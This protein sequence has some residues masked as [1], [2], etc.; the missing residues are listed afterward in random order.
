LKVLLLVIILDGLKDN[1]KSNS[2]NVVEL[3]GLVFIDM[4]PRR[5]YAQVGFTSDTDLLW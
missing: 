2:K 3:A 1:N 4:W 5:K